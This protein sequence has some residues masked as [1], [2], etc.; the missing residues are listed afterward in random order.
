[1]LRV[2]RRASFLK[3]TFLPRL[4]HTS[5]VKDRYFESALIEVES[6]SKNTTPTMARFAEEVRPLLPTP[7]PDAKEPPVMLV[8]GPE[9]L[10]W[11]ITKTGHSNSI[12]LG[13][14]GFVSFAPDLGA[15]LDHLCH[16][17]KVVL[18]SNMQEDVVTAVLSQLPEEPTFAHK[19]N[20]NHCFPLARMPN[21]YVKDLFRLG[22]PLQQ[23]VLLD[24]TELSGRFQRRNH[25]LANSMDDKLSELTDLL[26]VLEPLI[27]AASVFP[28]LDELNAHRIAERRR[29]QYAS[30]RWWIEKLSGERDE[31]SGIGALS[32]S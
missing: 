28:L 15:L 26:P 16:C 20:Q 18:W 24:P 31:P 7:E 17:F 21:T 30:P 9:D 27:D 10:L 5:G 13:E 4:R 6:W 29:P 32:Q 3:P 25:L 19:L 12:A 23:V 2:S 1:M 22:H 11:T 14:H 8:I